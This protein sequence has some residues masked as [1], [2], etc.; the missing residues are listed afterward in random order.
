[1]EFKLTLSQV[2]EI[3]SGNGQASILI[4]EMKAPTRKICYLQ[5]AVSIFEVQHSKSLMWIKKMV[6]MS[7]GKKIFLDGSWP[8]LT[9]KVM[10]INLLHRCPCCLEV[11]QLIKK[12]FRIRLCLIFR[13]RGMNWPIHLD[14]KYL[15]QNISS[16]KQS[17]P[18]WKYLN[19][20]IYNFLQ[21]HC[22]LVS[23]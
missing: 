19:L 8:L 10:H 16:S 13:Q 15:Y 5:S 14:T 18:R 9:E 20:L 7:M 11:Y 1:M 23:I 2:G 4:S 17:S 12:L 3:T 22:A 6:L 21:L